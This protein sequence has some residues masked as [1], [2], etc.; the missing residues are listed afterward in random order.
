MI[1][2][3]CL[4]QG[5]QPPGDLQHR[6]ELQGESQDSSGEVIIPCKAYSQERGHLPDQRGLAQPAAGG[7]HQAVDD[8]LPREGAAPAARARQPAD[9]LCCLPHDVPGLV[10]VRGAQGEAGGGR[11]AGLGGQKRSAEEA[12]A[13]LVEQ[14]KRATAAYSRNWFC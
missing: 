9:D 14:G 2:A 4:E 5:N 12:E 11:L 3:D 8:N 7:S 1:L 13:V 10:R 6:R